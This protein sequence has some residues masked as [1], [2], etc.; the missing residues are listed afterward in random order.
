ML[1]IKHTEKAQLER[2]AQKILKLSTAINGFLYIT[3]IPGT[4]EKLVHINKEGKVLWERDYV[5]SVDTFGMFNEREAIVMNVSESTI[6]IVDLL[7]HTFRSYPHN[8]A[9]ED[10]APM[11]IFVFS[12]TKLFTIVEKGDSSDNR[13]FLTYYSYQSQDMKE[14]AA[15]KSE[16]EWNSDMSFEK[17]NNHSKFAWWKPKLE[18]S[19]DF[20]TFD[21]QSDPAGKLRP[22]SVK[23]TLIQDHNI[24][25]L[26]L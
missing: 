18:A 7:T 5:D 6:E 16:G 2:P 1:L 9:F 11:D 3:T 13:L 8:Y 23:N 20:F 12:D 24:N 10:T 26:S 15:F 25:N 14:V 4:Y 19:I 22:I 17:V 21:L